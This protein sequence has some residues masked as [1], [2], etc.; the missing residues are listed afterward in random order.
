[1]DELFRQLLQLGV[2]ARFRE[3]DDSELVGNLPLT[4]NLSEDEFL[5][6]NSILIISNHDAEFLAR[7][8][9]P[10]TSGIWKMEGFF[11]FTQTLRS[12]S[13]ICYFFVGLTF[14]LT[15]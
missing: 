8:D 3:G 12:L 6:R 9:H 14:I 1:M 11:N 2:N 13:N 10:I 15:C 7:V 5:K 4:G